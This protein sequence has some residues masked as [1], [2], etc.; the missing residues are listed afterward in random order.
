M[1]L[2]TAVGGRLIG[3]FP[4][5][6]S[7]P[8]GPHGYITARYINFLTEDWSQAVGRLIQFNAKASPAGLEYLAHSVKTTGVKPLR[9]PAGPPGIQKPYIAQAVACET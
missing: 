8:P 7:V 3:Q 2:T 4:S 5:D 9:F 6:G 1:M